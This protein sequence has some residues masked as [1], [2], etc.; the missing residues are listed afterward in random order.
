MEERQKRWGKERMGE[1]K[2]E[3]G[4][5][6]TIRNREIETERETHTERNRERERERER[7]GET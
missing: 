6:E 1:K 7:K 3:R 2:K 4:D 5:E